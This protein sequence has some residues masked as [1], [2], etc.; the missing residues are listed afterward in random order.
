MNIEGYSHRP[1]FR[2][3]QVDAEIIGPIFMDMAQQGDLDRHSVVEAATNSKSLLHPFF[4]W[5]DTAAAHEW[6]LDQAR[7]MLQAITIKIIDS[8]GEQQE[9]RAFEVIIR[10][11]KTSDSVP[12]R[13]YVPVFELTEDEIAT[14]LVEAQREL[15]AWEARYKK[16]SSLAEGKA[17]FSQVFRAIHDSRDVLQEEAA[18]A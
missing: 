16:L 4:E 1:I 9:L 18:T 7:K 15:D 5:N 6:R 8:K 11:G 10:D 12:K 3:S 17:V 2:F 13:V 14:L